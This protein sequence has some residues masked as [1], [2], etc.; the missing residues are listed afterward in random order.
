MLCIVYALVHKSLD[1]RS[2][3]ITIRPSCN[4]YSHTNDDDYTLPS[5]LSV[6]CRLHFNFW[7]ACLPW[8]FR[9]SHPPTLRV[10][11]YQVC[12]IQTSHPSQ[13]ASLL[14]V[15]RPQFVQH[16]ISKNSLVSSGINWPLWGVPR[17]MTAHRCRSWL[18]RPALPSGTPLCYHTSLMMPG[19]VIIRPQSLVEAH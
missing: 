13:Y 10:S 12:L 17:Q 4:Q 15:Q 2:G 6:W 8:T 11:H 3:Y 14:Q 7:V 1:L 18:E 16:P 5:A 19:F 9:S